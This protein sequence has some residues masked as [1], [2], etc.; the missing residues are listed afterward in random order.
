MVAHAQLGCPFLFSS[1]V[2]SILN[3]SVLIIVNPSISKTTDYDFILPKKY[4]LS[5]HISMDE[6]FQMNEMESSKNLI[7]VYFY[8]L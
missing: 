4:I 1:Y 8:F 6:S 7:R 5:M 3:I 2:D